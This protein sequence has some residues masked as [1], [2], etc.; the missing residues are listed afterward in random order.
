MLRYS[1]YE[2]EQVRPSMAASLTR[3][4]SV[5]TLL[6]VAS[7]F[8]ARAQSAWNFAVSGDSRNCGD[9]VM[10]TIAATARTHGA[11]FY[12]HLGDVRAIYDFDQDIVRSREIQSRK[13]PLAIADYERMA[14]DDFIQ[15]QI[16]AFGS[17]PFII[18]IGNHELYPPKDRNQFVAQFADWLDT[19]TLR[20]QRLK[21]NPSDHRV[22]TYFHWIQGEL[23][24]F[25]SIMPV[26]NNSTKI[27]WHGSRM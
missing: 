24:S 14:W 9:L 18:G 10:P 16:A 7:V 11:Q 2:F 20:E 12:W 26:R 1:F 3:L 23:I 8:T 17:V 25:T 13:T 19:S 5:I 21:D 22:K 4:S 6:A 15:H 27:R